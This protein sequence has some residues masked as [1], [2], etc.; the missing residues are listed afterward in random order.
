[1]EWIINKQFK[2]LLKM[3]N[4]DFDGYKIWKLMEECVIQKII[5]M[6]KQLEETLVYNKHYNHFKCDV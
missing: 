6:K 2:I 1:L 5:K 3:D 4:Q